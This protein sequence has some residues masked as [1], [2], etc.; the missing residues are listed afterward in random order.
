[1]KVSVIGGGAWGTTLAQ[2]L[3][4]NQNEVLIRDVNKDFVNKINKYHVHPSFD[5]SIP[6]SIKA[7]LSLEEAISFAKIIVK[8]SVFVE[9]QFSQS[10]LQS[11][12]A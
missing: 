12:I 5:V 2:T 10:H 9:L 8:H 7:T 11:P 4:D 3:A 1:M 6:S